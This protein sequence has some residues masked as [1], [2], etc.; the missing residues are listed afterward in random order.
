[1]AY[2]V[3]V[4]RGFRAL[5]SNANLSPEMR[6][7]FQGGAAAL[8]CFLFTGLAGSSLRPESEFV[9]LWLAIG[10]MYG[11]LARRPAG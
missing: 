9:H 1:M 2:F 7:L 5:G 3:H 10:F 8:I 4:W 11:M 6:G